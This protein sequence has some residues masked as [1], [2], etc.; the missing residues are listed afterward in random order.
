MMSIKKNANTTN[1]LGYSKSQKNSK[2][3]I[4]SLNN[5]YQKCQDLELSLLHLAKNKRIKN[6]R[7]RNG[8]TKNKRGKNRRG[9]NTQANNEIANSEGTSNDASNNEQLWKQKE[10]GGEAKLDGVD[11]E[12]NE[13][14][15][16]SR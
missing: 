5:R 1:Y 15:I 16:G 6:K 8:R 7:S 11:V 3:L 9:K 12:A 13:R 10:G 14:A 2:E 4:S